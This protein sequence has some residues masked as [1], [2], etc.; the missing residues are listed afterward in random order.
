MA[1]WDCQ[2]LANI[3][4]ARSDASNW[5]DNS[6]NLWLFGGSGWDSTGR[7]GYLNDLWEFNPAAGEWVWMGGNNTI[8]CSTVG[9]S[10]YCGQ[11]GIYGSLGSP[12]SGNNPGSRLDAAFWMDSSGDLWLFGGFGYG[13]AGTIGFLNDL[14][15]YK[16]PV[17]S[18]VPVPTF[19]VSGGT[20]TSPQTVTI[21]DAVAGATIYYTTNGTT[22]TTS[23]TVYSSPITVSTSETIEAIATASGYTTS[24]VRAATYTLQAAPAHF[25]PRG[26][27]LHHGSIG[28]PHRHHTRSRHLLHHQRDNANDQFDPVQRCNHGVVDGDD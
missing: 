23:S 17:S 18:S 14:W 26:G 25:Q 11:P 13:S 9:G 24:A 20:Y 22:P 8:A 5:I 27:H 21:T 4:G 16:P 7:L 2:P 1:R 15:E 12:A 6:G 10:T 3:P 28:D 19:S